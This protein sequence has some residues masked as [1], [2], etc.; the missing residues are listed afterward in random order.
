M[1]YRR[2]IIMLSLLTLA[3]VVRAQVDENRKR[4][5]MPD[6]TTNDYEEWLRNEPLRPEQHDTL[7]I[8]PIAPSIPVDD[9]TKMEPKHPPVS[10]N[11]MTPKLRTEMQL[12]HQSHWLEEQRKSQVGGAMTVGVNPFSLLGYLLHK[13]IPDRKS[14]K[15][16]RR[17]RLQRI[18]DNY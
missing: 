12:A 13:I 9:P 1:D 17:E 3:I 18:L 8:G 7:G 10:I 14:K 11:I 16:R 2:C 15:Q 5:Q 4:I 6:S